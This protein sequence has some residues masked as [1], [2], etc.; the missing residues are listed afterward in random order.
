[1]VRQYITEKVFSE[2]SENQ[3]ELVDILNHNMTKLSVDVSW[4][5][6]LVSWQIGLLGAI[7]IAVVTTF[8]KLVVI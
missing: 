8:I 1:M 2:F 4:L 6:K 5:K 7:T 3:R